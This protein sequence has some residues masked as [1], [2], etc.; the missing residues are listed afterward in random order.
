MLVA[1]HNV[2]SN[3]EPWNLSSGYY[4]GKSL[5]VIAQETSLAALAF[6]SDGTKAY[7]V[8][9]TNNT[10][11]Q[12]TL[13]T[14]WDISTGSYA[15]KSLSVAAQETT[16][17]GLAFSSDGTKAY[18][19]G[20]VNDTI[21]QYTLSTAWDIST[22]SYASKSLSVAAQS[23]GPAGVAFSSDGTQAYV[24]E[25]AAANTIYQYTLST[26]WDISTGSYA[27]KSLS[28]APQDTATEDLAFS[29][30]GT[31]V[32]TM[33]RLGMKIFQYTLSTAWDISTGSY[34]SKSLSVTAQDN[35]P[36][37]LAFSSD[38]AKAYF[39]GSTNDR[40]YQYTLVD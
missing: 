21:Y 10:I 33:G 3:G 30:D 29:S 40:I 16:S 27:S 36:Y 9:S 2:I 4:S 15:S 31:K 24:V 22:G 17:F 6:S 7:A 32:Y 26:A 23:T 20:L 19:V 35:N 34:A 39:I 18:V 13:S 12:Y 25:R 38:G 28:V 37:S 14:A 1:A 11:Y 5:S 8:G